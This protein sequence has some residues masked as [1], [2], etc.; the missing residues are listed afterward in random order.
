VKIMRAKLLGVLAGAGAAAVAYA[1]LVERMRVEVD[2]YTVAVEA[3]GLPEPGITVLHLSDFHFRRG[4]RIQGRKAR[5]LLALLAREP[6]DIV[7]LT[8]DLIHDTTGLPMALRLIQRLR[9]QIGTYSVP[10][11]HDYQEYSMWGVL[12]PTW[13]PGAVPSPSDLLALAGRLRGFVRK[14]VRNELVRLPVASNDV[15]AMHAALRAI[16]VMPL[17]NRAIHVQTPRIDLWI[18]GLDDLT[19]GAPRVAAAL[20]DVPKGAPLVVLAHNP[21]V[22]LDP[23]LKEADLILA[24]HTHGGQIRLPGVGAAHTQGTHLGRDRAAGWFRRGRTRLFVSRGLGESI[25]LR[26]GVRPQA[27]LIRVVSHS[28]GAS[29]NTNTGNADQFPD[30]VPA[31]SISTVPARTA[32]LR[33]T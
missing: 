17:V 9:P 16:G 27:A 2:R 21:D 5:R 4:D 29:G 12:D 15:P 11:N 28:T 10:G 30:D 18:A 8:G 25:P 6:Y 22:F 26:F 23:R 7:A 32:A 31:R 13:Q 24:G 33:G 20:S 19:E 1:L 3:P 14:V